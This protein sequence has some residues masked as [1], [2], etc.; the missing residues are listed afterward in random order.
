MRSLARPNGIQTVVPNEI[1]DVRFAVARFWDLRHVSR[2][3]VKR[4]N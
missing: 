3:P 1:A 2:E 4:S